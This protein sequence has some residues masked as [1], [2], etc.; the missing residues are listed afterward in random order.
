MW[1]SEVCC[2]VQ[3]FWSCSH[4]LVLFV[5]AAQNYWDELFVINLEKCVQMEI[6]TVTTYST[7]I[8]LRFLS[9]FRKGKKPS[10]HS[11]HPYCIGNA[12]CLG[13]VVCVFV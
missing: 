10:M 4:G 11:K 7:E 3:C 5:H 1:V 6:S 9:S 12:M 2:V 13:R 8:G